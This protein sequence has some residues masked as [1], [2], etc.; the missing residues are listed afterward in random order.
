MD[1]W[2]EQI[3][4]GVDLS[5]PDASWHLFVNMMRLV[6][7]AALTWLT[8]LFVAVGG[9]LGWWRG[10]F[11]EGVVWAAVLGPFGWLVILL[12]PRRELPPPLPRGR[13]R[14]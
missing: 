14:R 9:L 5:A 2:L 6:P 1:E 11:W 8:L 10:R 3:T 7:W 4:D 12:R 13:R